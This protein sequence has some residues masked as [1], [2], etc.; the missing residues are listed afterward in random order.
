MNCPFLKEARV[1]YC[2]KSAI[3]K[4]IR[5]GG[6]VAQETCSSSQYK[7]C[8]AY[9]PFAEDSGSPQC[10]YLRESHAQYCATSA[11][12][13]FIPYTEPLLSRCTGDS[14]RYCDVYLE[15]SATQSCGG[16]DTSV[17]GIRVATWLHYSANHMWL[18]AAQ[19]GCCHVGLDAFLTRVVGGVE[20]VTF[21]KQTGPHC[22]SAVLTVRGVDLEV[23]FPK[24]ILLTASN[25]YLRANPARL[26]TDPYGMGWLFQGVALPDQPPVASGLIS[27]EAVPAWMEREIGRMSAFLSD[28]WNSRRGAT[29]MND[30][31]VF[32]PDVLQHLSHEET[33]RLFR[34]FFMTSRTPPG[35]FKW[36]RSKH[37]TILQ[38]HRGKLLFGAGML[39]ALALGWRGFPL[40]RFARV[41]QPVAFSH[42]IHTEKAG[43]KCDDCHSLRADGTFAG[44]PTLDKCSSCH[45]Q[46]MGTSAEEKRFIDVFVT[47]N[48][49]IPWQD[50]ARQPENV[51][52]SHSF[53]IK[54]AQIDCRQCHGATRRERY[55]RAPPRIDRIS[56]YSASPHF[57]DM[58]ACEDCHRQR[59]AANSCLACHK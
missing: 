58:N 39:A 17:G 38:I 9:R 44:I 59:G 27:G 31:G 34:E 26:A 57:Q 36:R 32:S 35:L 51:Y 21:L 48:R 53:H 46:P 25:L 40:V 47:P 33:L 42:K 50:Y 28:C 4:L 18:D 8:A 7:Q 15:A 41:P 43:A 23:T 14:Y 3:R 5:I 1:K 52:F 2:D 10:P 49:E 54:L 30:G 19:G 56:G 55:A 20:R 22:P 13:R 24:P 16:R 11:I 45:A 12:S 6:N 37:M 29:L